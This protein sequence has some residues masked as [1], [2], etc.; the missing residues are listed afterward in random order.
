MANGLFCSESLPVTPKYRHNST[1]SN[2]SNSENTPPELAHLIGKT[3]D[4]LCT[5]V[6][7][8]REL[9]KPVMQLLQPCK[10]QQYQQQQQMASFNHPP[11]KA[12]H[13]SV[14]L[15]DDRVLQNLL[16]NEE[17]YLPCTADYF[18]YVQVEVKPHMR[19][20][21]ADWMLDVCQELCF[22]QLEVFCLAMN[23]MD[24]FLAICR[25]SKSQL[26][27][28][29]TAC[30]FLASKFKAVD[31]I[32]SEKLVMYT[33]YSINAQELKDWELLVLHKLR[34]ELTSTTALDYLDHILPRLCL[35]PSVDIHSLRLKTETIITL[36]AKDYNFS[37]KS[38]SLIAATSIFTALRS[39]N[40]ESKT[41]TLKNILTSQVEDMDTMRQRELQG[42]L[43]DKILKDAKICLQILTLASSKDMEHNC[44]HMAETLPEYLTGHVTKY[45]PVSPDT[46]VS[47][48]SESSSYHHQPAGYL[49][50][51][52][53]YPQVSS[54]HGVSSSSYSQT[55]H[56]QLTSTPS[57]QEIPPDFASAVDV[58]SDFNSSVLQAVLSPSDSHLTNSILCS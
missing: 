1:D 51:E 31:H 17:R 56:H 26:Q 39:C 16:R 22:D 41:K 3:C 34:W 32:S 9:Q 10:Q 24:R 36:A 55:N 30:F 28:L 14:I 57:K 52:A 48:S 33:D 12:D 27:L 11:V 7:D 50:Q 23:F 38:P 5:E 25:I 19:K 40:T 42:A 13:D 4:L 18:K 53:V 47:Q 2:D 21:V 15:Q 58:F 45:T 37:Y 6:I 43:S 49:P 35:P 44:A 29:G 8:E 20:I 46:T 54:S